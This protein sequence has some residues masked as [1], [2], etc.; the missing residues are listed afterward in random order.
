MRRRRK[1]T[2]AQWM[3]FLRKT[4]KLRAREREGK[5]IPTF[6]MISSKPPVIESAAEEEKN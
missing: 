3:E 1:P 4:K 6:L 5:E 2:P